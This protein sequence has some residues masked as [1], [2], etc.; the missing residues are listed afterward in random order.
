LRSDQGIGEEDEEF[1][2]V[3]IG[4]EVRSESTDRAVVLGVTDYARDPRESECDFRRLFRTGND[5]GRDTV[6]KPLVPRVNRKPARLDEKLI[7]A[8]EPRRLTR[9]ENDRITNH[10]RDS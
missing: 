9:C 6:E 5:G 7:R 10:G 3:R 8:A 1:A 4:F 2:L